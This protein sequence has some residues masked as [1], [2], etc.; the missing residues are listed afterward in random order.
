MAG[1]DAEL[2]QKLLDLTAKG[3]CH[4]GINKMI[5]CPFDGTKRVSVTYGA[6]IRGELRMV[7]ISAWECNNH[8]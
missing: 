8:R 5:R 4:Y 2:Q 6:E 7:T 3:K 1:L